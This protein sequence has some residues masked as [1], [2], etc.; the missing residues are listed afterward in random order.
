MEFVDS[1]TIRMDKVVNELDRFVFDF[2][3][4]LEKQ[5]DYV[6]VSGYVAIL[7]GRSRGY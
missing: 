1:K 2:I 5:A 3:K 4:I 7:Y 6:I